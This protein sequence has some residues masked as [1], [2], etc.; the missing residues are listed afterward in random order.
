MGDLD[1]IIP[2]DFRGRFS[3]GPNESLEIDLGDGRRLVIWGATEIYVS[4]AL[5]QEDKP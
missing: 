1:T 3:P 2:P 5:T 4:D